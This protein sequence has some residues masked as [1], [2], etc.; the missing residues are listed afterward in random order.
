MVGDSSSRVT[1]TNCSDLLSKSK[2][3]PQIVT[4]IPKGF[5]ALHGCA[6]F[7]GSPHCSKR[8]KPPIVKEI[9]AYCLGRKRMGST[10]LPLRRISKCS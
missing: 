7:Q 8:G 3:P 10:G 1:S 2:I 6:Q 9:L 5:N 4:A